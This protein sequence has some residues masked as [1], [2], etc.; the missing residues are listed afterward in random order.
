MS[1]RSAFA[2]R[3]VNVLS[4]FQ[5]CVREEKEVGGE[6]GEGGASGGAG[7]ALLRL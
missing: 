3:G 5:D 1:C 6:D 4:D 2:A 7:H